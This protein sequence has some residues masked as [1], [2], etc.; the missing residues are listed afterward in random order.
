MDDTRLLQRFYFSSSLIQ[1]NEIFT[2]GETEAQG[3]II[4]FDLTSRNSFENAI[5]WKKDVD[6]KCVLEDG[7]P[8]PCMLLA[9]KVSEGIAI[10]G[11]AIIMTF[12]FQC[13]LRQRQ[14]N[15]WEIETLCREHSFIG[16]TETSA[17]DDLMVGDCMRLV[18]TLRSLNIPYHANPYFQDFHSL[19]SSKLR[20]LIEVMVRFNRFQTTDICGPSLKLGKRKEEESNGTVSRKGAGSCSC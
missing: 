20:F 13:D 7:A 15:Q 2:N 18:K 5:K 16:W 6:S 3:C 12:P 10:N 9:N 1:D 19:L 17:K 8:V 14:V 11:Y 4:M